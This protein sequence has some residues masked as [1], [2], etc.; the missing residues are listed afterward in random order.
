MVIH[1]HFPL[2]RQ[3]G[4]QRGKHCSI[5]WAVQAVLA[6]DKSGI[7]SISTRCTRTTAAGYKRCYLSP[8][9]LTSKVLAVTSKCALS[10]LWIGARIADNEGRRRLGQS[11]GTVSG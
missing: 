11:S 7:D 4:P 5:S 3:A 9:H 1:N 10:K 2:D 8:T 6:A